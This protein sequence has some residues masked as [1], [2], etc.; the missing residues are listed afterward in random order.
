MQA[1]DEAIM[2]RIDGQR[3]LADLRRWTEFNA[4][5]LEYSD[6]ARLPARSAFG[7]S[8]LALGGEVE[9][10]ASPIG[11]A[12][13]SGVHAPRVTTFTSTLPRVAWL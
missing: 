1:E 3:M 6:P 9:S 11:R 13:R 10:N 5:Y 8:G 4:V 2:I 12:S 7:A